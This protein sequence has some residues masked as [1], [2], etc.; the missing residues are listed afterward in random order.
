MICFDLYLV[1]VYIFWNFSNNDGSIAQYDIQ[2][3]AYSIRCHK[4]AQLNG[5]N[6]RLGVASADIFII[7][8]IHSIMLIVFIII[9]VCFVSF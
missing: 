6:D 2:A 7:I 1:V 8:I 3:V 4:S 9:E 5:N